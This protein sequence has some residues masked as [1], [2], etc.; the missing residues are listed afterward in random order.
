ML[1]AAMFGALA[2]LTIIFAGTQASK[3]ATALEAARSLPSM[4]T[5]AIV[6][7]AGEGSLLFNL[8]AGGACYRWAANPT[9]GL[10]C[11]AGFAFADY[12]YRNRTR[13]LYLLAYAGGRMARVTTPCVIASGVKYYC[14]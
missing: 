13:L 7:V 12:I 10:W 6:Q 1:R 11:G 8:A 5:P 3:P 4:G 14:L 2:A 9:A